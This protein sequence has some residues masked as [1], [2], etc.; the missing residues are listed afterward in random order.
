MKKE[1]G[2]MLNIVIEIVSMFFFCKA[3]DIV[4]FVLNSR[5]NLD[6]KM[7]LDTLFEVVSIYKLLLVI[8]GSVNP[9]IYEI[10]SKK[11]RN[12]LFCIIKCG[13]KTSAE[14]SSSATSIKMSR[15]EIL[16]YSTNQGS[17]L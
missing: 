2:N 3:I 7:N 1:G 5:Q 13:K 8:N 14:F 4:S 11:Y 9:I 6:I 16:K 12:I 15:G 17:I 10:F